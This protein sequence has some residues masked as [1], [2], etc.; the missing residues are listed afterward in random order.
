MKKQIDIKKEIENLI[1]Y[2][3][4]NKWNDEEFEVLADCYFALE[5]IQE[6]AKK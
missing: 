1:S 6:G 3:L 4:Q 5:G 2:V